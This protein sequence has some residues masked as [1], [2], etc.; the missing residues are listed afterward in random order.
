[1]AS[2]V[3]AQERL[4]GW[5]C[6]SSP[7]SRRPYVDLRVRLTKG[8]RTHNS[9]HGGVLSSRVPTTPVMALQCPGWQHSGGDGC[10]GPKVMEESCFTGLMSRCCPARVRG[11][12]S[13]LF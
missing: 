10:T 3:P 2:P 1:V 9:G 11:R 5:P 4:R 8:Q 7:F 12:H 6:G 13:Y